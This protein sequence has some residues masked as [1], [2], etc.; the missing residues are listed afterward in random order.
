MRNMASLAVTSGLLLAAAAACI[1]GCGTDAASC[2]NL[3]TCPSYGCSLPPTA[4]AGASPSCGVFACP[5]GT[6]SGN[7]TQDNPYPTLT[8]ALANTG[9]KA[10]YAC[11]QTF[12]EAG[13]VDVPAGAT[14]LGGLDAANGWVLTA[15][16]TTVKTAATVTTAGGSEIAMVVNTG[17]KK[18]ST[19]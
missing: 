6:K 1:A 14:I 11:N 5:T 17:A 15:T 10:V 4:D 8:A 2:E 12:E 9:N 16:H 18:V 7:G 19:I 3:L 13:T